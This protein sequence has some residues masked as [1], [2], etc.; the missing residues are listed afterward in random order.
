MVSLSE[1]I[2]VL[3]CESSYGGFES[4]TTPQAPGTP[5]E[6]RPRYEREQT[7]VRIS[8]WGRLQIP[9][10]KEQRKFPTLSIRVRF[11]VVGLLPAR[12][13]QR[14]PPKFAARGAIPR[15]GAT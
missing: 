1:W 14:E 4:P 15:G 10:S 3:D 12:I 9:A 6:R 11:P 5:A 8:P 7:G 13:D 2:K